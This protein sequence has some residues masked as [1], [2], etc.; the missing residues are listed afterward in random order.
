V[1]ASAVIAGQHSAQE[2]TARY[3]RRQEHHGHADERARAARR[4]IA[5]RHRDEQQQRGGPIWFQYVRD[6]SS[7][8]N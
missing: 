6:T 8:A 1:P 2:Q 5:E 7:S 3:Q 4:A